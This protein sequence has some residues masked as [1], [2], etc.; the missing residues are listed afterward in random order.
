GWPVRIGGRDGQFDDIAPAGRVW[1]CDLRSGEG[2]PGYID[3]GSTGTARMK[4]ASET[5]WERHRRSGSCVIRTWC[6]VGAIVVALGGCFLVPG[7]PDRPD[8]SALSGPVPYVEDC[9]AC[10]ARQS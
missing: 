3:L 1:D 2:R 8:P 10:Q 6:L 9:K 5:P 4:P 7:S